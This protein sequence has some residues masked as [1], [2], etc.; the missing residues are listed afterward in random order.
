MFERVLVGLDLT[1]AAETVLRGLPQLRGLGTRV[2]ILAHVP[3]AL[4]D[5]FADPEIEREMHLARLE[6]LGSFLAREGFEV[7]AR[8]GEGDPARSLVDLAGAEGASLVALGSR[9]RSRVREAFLGSL[10]MDVLRA[11]TTPVLLFHVDA[12]AVDE[13][14]PA[15][16]SSSDRTL[17][18]RI[19]FA[20]DFSDAANNAFIW[21]E[22]IAAL[23]HGQ[24]KLVHATPL[25]LEESPKAEDELAILTERLDR[26]GARAVQST[27]VH[28]AP[29]QAILMAAA[30]DPPP[31]VVMG[32][33]GRGF[34]GRTVLGSVARAVAQ[35]SRAPLL[36]VPP[37]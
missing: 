24:V 1:T 13:A 18:D 37:A 6:A 26:A 5:P 33:H 20:T 11:A 16:P 3:A 7:R 35:E 23:T 4:G 34:L 21:V 17:G 12:D 30:G 2:F 19:L 25:A 29:A 27:V 10:A 15:P 28:P 31:L 32:T 36:L 9:S 14:P 22:R 8:I